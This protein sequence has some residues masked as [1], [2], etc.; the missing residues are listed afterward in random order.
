MISGIKIND[1]IVIFKSNKI[2]SKGEDRLVMYNHLSL[3]KDT[4]I[5]KKYS[6]IYTV[7]GLMLIEPNN[8]MDKISKYK[9]LL[10][11]CKKY[12]KLQKNGILLIN[13]KENCPKENE[14]VKKEIEIS[15]NN[16][17]FYDTGDFEVYCF[18]QIFENK[19]EEKL[20]FKDENKTY[21]NYFLV[22]GFNKN[23]KK[24]IIKLYKLFYYENDNKKNKIEYIQDIIIKK[25][26]VE[27]R[28]I[29]EKII[30]FKGPISCIIQ[31]SQDGKILVSCWDGHLYLLNKPNIQDYITYDENNK[32]IIFKEFF[33]KQNY[34]E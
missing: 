9:F 2:N 31:S 4:I 5:K 13:I 25:I 23:K 24:G 28:S 34:F 30:K 20:I 26:Y 12:Y 15:I 7:N 29:K 3:I 32:K 21:T 10:C 22:G 6:Y 17:I 14:Y 11:A 33:S 27:N 8:N 16:H 18:C 19:N 1:K